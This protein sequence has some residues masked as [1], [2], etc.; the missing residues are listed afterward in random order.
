LRRL[1]DQRNIS[2]QD[3]TDDSVIITMW[4]EDESLDEALW[5]LLY[6]AFPANDYERDCHA[7]LSII[8]GNPE[9]TDLARNRLLDLAK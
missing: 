4:F 8:V 5:K 9:W 3:E 1:D 6:V 2:D 7:G